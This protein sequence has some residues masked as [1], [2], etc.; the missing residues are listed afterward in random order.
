M[1]SRSLRTT[2]SHVAASVPTSATSSPS[3]ANGTAPRSC[4]G[5]LWQATQ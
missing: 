3:N 2:A 5:S 1:P 4:M